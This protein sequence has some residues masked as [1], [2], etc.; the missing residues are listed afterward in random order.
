MIRYFE[1]LILIFFI[2]SFCGWAM[3]S[4]GGIFKEKKFINRGFLIGPYCP[5]YGCGVVG[6][7]VLLSKYQNDFYA[8]FILV[9]V[10]CGSLEY[11]TSY[12]MEKLFNARW[13]DYH[14]H[15]FNINGRICLETLIPFGIVGTIIVCTLNPI[16]YSYFDNISDQ[17]INIITLIISVLFIIDFIVSFCIISSFKGATYNQ[18][19]NTEEISN[20]VKE[21]TEEI[22]DVLK[23]KTEDTIMHLESNVIVL[24]RGI[25]VR[26]LKI[27]RKVRYTG[28]KIQY[29]A[30]APIK[31]LSTELKVRTYNIRNAID[32]KKDKIDEQ[33]KNKQREISN[34]IIENFK[35]RS[36]LS[37]RLMDA[38]PKMSIKLNK[39]EDNKLQK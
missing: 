36:I 30:I 10:M 37:K 8:L 27:E 16:L 20:K 4:F 7:T 19:D 31:E 15:K 14:N 29:K 32:E 21:K 13:W 11:F 24:R 17:T 22:S 38:F 12:I 9:T 1:Y 34:Q 2:Y 25:R 28:R 35:K 33:L 39:K 5:V 3:E 18:K 23:D 6:I 26:R